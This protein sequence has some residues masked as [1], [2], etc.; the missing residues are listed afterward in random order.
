MAVQVKFLARYNQVK[1]G[2]LF[3]S[4]SADYVEKIV[5]RQSS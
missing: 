4:G 3:L 2:D 1:T 5:T